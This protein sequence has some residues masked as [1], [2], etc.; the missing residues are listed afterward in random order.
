MNFTHLSVRAALLGLALVLAACG[1][2]HLQHRVI[3]A[4][5]GTEWQTEG[6][7]ETAPL[8]L[9]SPRFDDKG[10]SFAVLSRR[11]EREYGFDT[12]Y[13]ETRSVKDPN[14][15]AMAVGATTM[16]LFCLVSSDECFGD[17][18]RWNRSGKRKRN[19]AP[20]G[21]TRPLDE[22]YN[23]RVTAAVQL[24]GFDAAGAPL[25]LVEADYATNQ[26][27][28]NV[29]LKGLVE[30]MPARPDQ[31][32]VVAFIR[33][34]QVGTAKYRVS[35]AELLRLK[36]HAER[37]LP[38]AERQALVIA[39]LKARLVDQ[40]HAGA[41]PHFAALEALPVKLPPSFLYLYAQS[42]LKTGARE[43]GRDYLQKYLGA[44]GEGGL[45]VDE[46]RA[47]LAAAP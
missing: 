39:R 9:A 18:G 6:R 45:Y 44:S 24:R 31:V 11:V 34:R 35:S 42:L 43:R 4:G 32:D 16:G 41:L 3:E 30:Q 25:G 23:G 28:L 22:K 5:R 40:D 20:T 38:P 27:L 46:A 15:L 13:D 14:V 21:R 33:E 19:V 47:L 8:L 12:Y 36:P 17:T 7:V 26:G 37:W 2:R 1:D 10:L 29:P